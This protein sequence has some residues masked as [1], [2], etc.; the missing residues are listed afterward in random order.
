MGWP[1]DAECAHYAG[2][3]HLLQCRPATLSSP[4]PRDEF[5]ALKEQTV[6]GADAKNH[7]TPSPIPAPPDFPVTWKDGD[8]ERISWKLDPMH[9]PEPVTPMMDWFGQ[10]F[11]E[12][13]N[14][15]SQASQTPIRVELR[16]INTYFYNGSVPMVPPE[17]ME[18]RRKQAQEKLRLNIARLWEWWDGELLPEVKEHLAFWEAFD[19]RGATMP[20]WSPRRAA[21]CATAPSWPGS[22]TF[23][24][25]SA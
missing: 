24:P 8:D 3:L 9:F 6:S 12:G 19:R 22:T 10:V 23:Q 5:R 17:E 25:S 18:G 13:Y 1:V 14:R 16:R 4:Q 7:Q 21:S 15:A 2:Q 11:S 20:A